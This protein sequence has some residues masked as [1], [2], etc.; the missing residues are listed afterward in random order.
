MKTIHINFVERDYC[1][2]MCFFP[3]RKKC[4]VYH[5]TDQLRQKLDFLEGRSS[6]FTRICALPPEVSQWEFY[7]TRKTEKKKKN[8]KKKKERKKRFQKKKKKKKKKKKRKKKKRKTK[9]A[10]RE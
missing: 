6:L 4:S 2:N 1:E 5:R 7:R 9:T 10:P 3:S 8:E